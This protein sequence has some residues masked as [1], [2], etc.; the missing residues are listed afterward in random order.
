VRCKVILSAYPPSLAPVSI[1]FCPFLRD[2]IVY[3][4]LQVLF[5]RF[6]F[7]TNLASRRSH[8]HRL[9]QLCFL[10]LGLQSDL[11][12]FEVPLAYSD[13]FRRSSCHCK[14]NPHFRNASFWDTYD[15]R[16]FVSHRV[17]LFVYSVK[18]WMQKNY[19]SGCLSDFE[20]LGG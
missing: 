14:L 3:M 6:D 4:S 17:V 20:V 19:I 10:G 13:L 16:A 11:L 12:L 15:C 9:S 7:L 2:V 18:Q 8:R 5:P 1:P